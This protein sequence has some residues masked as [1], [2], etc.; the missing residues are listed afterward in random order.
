MING[1]FINNNNTIK[2]SGFENK[3][4]YTCEKIENP[5]KTTEISPIF[6]MDYSYSMAGTNSIAATSSLKL[7]LNNIFNTHTES[8]K[9]AQVIFF[10]RDAHLITVTKDNYNDM[11]DVVLLDY[12]SDHIT[13][14]KSKGKFS[15][16]GTN[17]I[18]AFTLFL[19]NISN[20]N[21]DIHIIFLTDGGFSTITNITYT[22]CWNK[23]GESIKQSK[24]NVIINTIGF[25]NDNVKNIQDMKIILEKYG[26]TLT[27]NTLTKP[28]EI[29]PTFENLVNSMNNSQISKICIEK[30]E[31]IEGQTIY[32]TDKLFT[33]LVNN[34]PIPTIVNGLSNEWITQVIK[35]EIDVGLEIKKICD[36]ISK[37][38]N[39]Q[40]NTHKIQYNDLWKNT[41][42]YYNIVSKKYVEL[43][44]QYTSLKT[45]AVCYW[46]DLKDQL[47][48]LTK[49]LND[50]Q[51]LNSST[52][53]EKQS[54]EK[55]TNINMSMKHT[56]ALE[57]RKYKNNNTNNTNQQIN[58]ITVNYQ[59]K[60]NIISLTYG[61]NI[62][63]MKS[64]LN[65]LNET[66][67]CFYSMSNWTDN[68]NSVFCIPISYKWRELDD[69][70]TSNA[71]IKNV[72]IS[73]YM[74]LDSYHELQKQYTD[75]IIPEHNVLYGNTNYVKSVDT[76]CNAVL[77]IA[78]DPYFTNKQQIVKEQLSH[79]I[80][81]SS[82]AFRSS[83]LLIYGPAIK[84]C[85]DK[86]V[87]EYNTK[88]E[89]ILVLL[90]NTFKLLS[91]TNY[92][93]YDKINNKL[94]MKDIL[95]NIAIGN[96][97]PYLFKNP[98]DIIL[99]VM[100]ANQ[101]AFVDA[102]TE[103]SKSDINININVTEFKIQIWKMI[104]RYMII[105]TDDESIQKQLFVPASFDLLS[106]DELLSKKNENI[107]NI[108]QYMLSS[109]KIKNKTSKRLNKKIDDIFKETLYI[110]YL[111]NFSESVNSYLDEFNNT[112]IFNKMNIKETPIADYF[113]D[114]NIK[115]I[116]YWGILELGCYGNKNCYP[117][118][119]RDSIC[120]DVINRVNTKYDQSLQDIFNKSEEYTLF[121]QRMK[122]CCHFPIT[123]TNLQAANINELFRKIQYE[124]LNYNDFE[125]AVYN[126]MNE[127]FKELC[128]NIKEIDN[129]NVLNN[130][131]NYIKNTAK[132]PYKLVIKN[133]G[134]P[135]SAPSYIKSPYFL[136]NLENEDFLTYYKPLGI[137]KSRK[138]LYKSWTYN[139]HNYMIEKVQLLNKDEFVRNICNFI[140]ETGINHPVDEIMKRQL[141]VY[142]NDFK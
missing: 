1:N 77:P 131:Y 133:N 18:S 52:L 135:H 88:T 110:K 93:V 81:G 31:F 137:Y 112:F 114:E 84:Y 30:H 53:S 39:T 27:Y 15:G 51:L 127:L 54:F 106:N 100:T 98:W 111:I 85:F 132:K 73:Q 40:F 12:N 116:Y 2:V 95:Y 123:F 4:K 50:V 24:K 91:S 7:S 60:D 41:Y 11:I 22:S 17:P 122:E 42:N 125:V 6:I 99:Y 96:T 23:I 71:N 126:I 76:Q 28:E 104:L 102:L 32:T 139:L 89:N 103:Y 108:E 66:F 101:Q 57:R 105:Y 141:E 117:M 83:H 86:L 90:I 58:Q 16:D 47:V 21:N 8:T 118:K 26:I 64:N 74:T 36:E 25:K 94:E 140:K 69:Y 113:T 33:E 56:R 121:R 78:T 62:I 67:E 107:E 68:I 43:Q 38:S 14:F 129:I 120:K 61:V 75:V 37:I 130:L 134:L 70:D 82:S 5:I 97:A 19:D 3:Y 46:T 115:D 142:Y 29:L 9:Y 10:G 128:E 80:V 55:A 79:M 92:I 87:K 20:L 45:R 13:E 119:S 124:E 65:L 48:I 35:L 138:Q 44:S 136:Q 72:S 34:N 49:I 59:D 109:D 63:N